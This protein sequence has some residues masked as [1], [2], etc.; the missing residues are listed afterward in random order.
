[1]VSINLRQP[2][3]NYTGKKILTVNCQINEAEVLHLFG[4]SG[5]GKTTLLNLIAGFLRPVS[6]IIRVDGTTWFD[7]SAGVDLPVNRR[8]PGFVFQHYALFQ[9][10]TVTGQL[11]FASAD[12]LLNNRLIKMASLESVRDCYPA[13]LSA[14]Q[15]QRLAIIRALAA[16][17]RLLLMDEPF[18]AL[19]EDTKTSFMDELQQFIQEYKM[20][21]IV[22]SHNH[23][24]MKELS[25]GRLD[26]AECL[27]QV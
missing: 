1:M 5:S 6:G 2:I 16:K 24:E 17:P 15:Q 20:A 25:T 7:S 4:V 21:C 23:A 18:S 11:R 14:G 3:K 13:R 9:Q 26:M 10:M 19:D 12:E 22:A 27:S 8:R